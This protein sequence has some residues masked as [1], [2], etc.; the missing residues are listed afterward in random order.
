[1][2]TRYFWMNLG[3]CEGITKAG[4]RCMNYERKPYERRPGDWVFPRTCYLHKDQEL[5]NKLEEKRGTDS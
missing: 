4:V 3:Q 5:S 2:T 1:M